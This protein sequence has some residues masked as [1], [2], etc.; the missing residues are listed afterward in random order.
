M[1]TTPQVYTDDSIDFSDLGRRARRGLGKVIGLGLLGL[2]LGVIFSVVVTTKR[3]AISTL[4]VTFGFS[5]FEHGNYPNGSKFQADDI[6]APDVINDAVN[7]LRLQGVAPDF[8]SR[9]RGSIGVSGF[10]SPGITKE[11]DRLRAAG[12]TLA[13]FFPDEYEISLSLPRDYPLDVRDRELLLSAIV[14]AYQAKFRRTYVALPAEF[15]NAFDSLK[16]A[17]FVEYEIILTKEMQSL[18]S[19]LE[20]QILRAKQYRSP[21]TNLSFQDLLKETELFTQI[22][23][24]DVLGLIYVNGLSKDRTYAMVKMD[25]YLR[26]LEDQEQ[27]L[28]EEESV[29]LNLL[30]K[31]QDRTQSYVLGIKTQAAQPR[32]DSPVLDQGLIE[33]LVANDAY[34]FLVRRALDAGLAVKRVQADKA[35][36][37]DRRQRMEMFTKGEIKDQAAAI[38]RTTSA[39]ESLEAGYQVLLKKVRAA[40]DDF[41]RQEYADAVR[42]TM[43]P[44]TD[45]LLLSIVGG[46]LIG[47]VTG[48]A[49]GLALSLLDSSRSRPP[50]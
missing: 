44:R 39:L 48:L 13:P 43:Q 6:R 7:Q 33:S 36:M 9:I 16:T 21:T 41:A 37:L 47:L 4:R 31:T 22:R 38:A 42:I 50:V 45:S 5:G 20:Q 1:D 26:T 34:N 18:A 29:V 12:Q 11:R 28:K 40:L 19:F 23:L 8:S 32:S 49:L 30:T 27:R 14:Q 17:D 10:I 2:S 24:N 46:G 25:Y 35:Q 3:S 15:D